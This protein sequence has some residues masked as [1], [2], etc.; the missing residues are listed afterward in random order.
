MSLTCEHNDDNV[1]TVDSDDGATAEYT[2]MWHSFSL[3]L[4]PH[5]EFQARSKHVYC[6]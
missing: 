1:T 5:T 4:R 3:A 6:F 2:Y